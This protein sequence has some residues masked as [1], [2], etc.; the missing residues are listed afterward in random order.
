MSENGLHPRQVPVVPKELGGKWIA[1]D[2]TGPKIIASGETLTV[3]RAAALNAGEENA[4]YEKCPARTSA[5]LER[6]VEVSLPKLP[7]RSDARFG[8]WHEHLE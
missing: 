6:R 3:A 2:S 8:R 5:S 4:L 1:W 7:S